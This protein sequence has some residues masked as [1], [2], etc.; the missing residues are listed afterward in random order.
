[1]LEGN[2]LLLQ[3]PGWQQLKALADYTIYINAAP[4]LLRDRLIERKIRGGLSPQQA[5]NF[6]LATDGPNVFKVLQFSQPADCHLVMDRDMSYRKAWTT[7]GKTRRWQVFPIHA[8]VY[9]SR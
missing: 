7:I 3:Q 5:E 9:R 4:E 6:Y 2:W 8:V 1:M